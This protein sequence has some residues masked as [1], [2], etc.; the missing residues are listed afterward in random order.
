MKHSYFHVL[1]FLEEVLY[2]VFS[3]ILKVF[4]LPSNK[5]IPSHAKR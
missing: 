2:W 3:I 1:L 5:F 4:M